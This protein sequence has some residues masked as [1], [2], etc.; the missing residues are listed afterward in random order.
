MP[1]LGVSGM[2]HLTY[3]GNVESTAI[4]QLVG[5]NTMREFLVAVDARYDPETDTTRVGFRYA[6]E[7]EVQ[8]HVTT[9]HWA[10]RFLVQKEIWS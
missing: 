5:P 4:G 9:N 6:T 7:T 8:E 3:P 1:D 10:F 2:K